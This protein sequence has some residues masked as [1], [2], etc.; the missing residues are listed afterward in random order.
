MQNMEQPSR[1]QQAFH[2]YTSGYEPSS[3]PEPDLPFSVYERV[4]PPYSPE[5]FA[6]ASSQP[7]HQTQQ[8]SYASQM[9]GETVYKNTL[10]ALLC[11]VCF[12]V[13]GL[14]FLLF[15]NKDRLVRFHAMQSLLFF[16][17]VNVLYFP[18]ISIMANQTPF[19]FGFAIFAFVIM[20][21]VA[22]VAWIVG[23]VSAANGR[24]VKLPF[25]GEIAERFAN[26]GT[27]LK[28]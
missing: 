4:Q 27:S 19:L 20:N 2:D 25:V 7:S 26:S 24:Y 23:L 28:P 22:A 6:S 3:V 12:W 17:A 15:D 9:P 10:P 11:Y 14:L 21:I 8:A 16:G 13:T 18:F 5:Q 1:Q